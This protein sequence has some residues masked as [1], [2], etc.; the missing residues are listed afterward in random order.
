M[1]LKLGTDGDLSIGRG[2]AR[3]SGTEYVGQLLSNKLKTLYGEWELN[4]T[5]GLPWFSDLLT[6]NYNAGLIYNW[7]YKTLSE[8]EYVVSVDNLTLGVVKDERQLFIY[9]E[10]TS[11]YGPLSKEVKL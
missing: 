10:V 2:A 4:K 11:L 7:V 5:I 1:N 3:T 9:F 8:C 6:H